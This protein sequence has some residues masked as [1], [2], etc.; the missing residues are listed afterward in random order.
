MRMATATRNLAELETARAARARAAR[1]RAEARRRAAMQARSR[2]RARDR[3]VRT[4]AVRR[5]RPVRAPRRPRLL[6]RRVRRY[7]PLERSSDR[8]RY[9]RAALAVIAVGSYSRVAGLPTCV[10]SSRGNLHPFRRRWLPARPE[11]RGPLPCWRWWRS[12]R[13]ADEAPDHATIS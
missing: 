10:S 4:R 12:Q 5:V 1:Q 8:E 11:W 6:R 3:R 13:C 7:Q 9:G 2:P